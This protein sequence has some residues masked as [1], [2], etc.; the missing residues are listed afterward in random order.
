MKQCSLDARSE[1]QRRTPFSGRVWE[2]E[3]AT[4]PSLV[5]AQCAASES[6]R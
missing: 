5:L 3:G 1:E 6:P 2:R 4:R